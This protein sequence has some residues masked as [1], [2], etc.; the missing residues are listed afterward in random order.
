MTPS[1]LGFIAEATPIRSSAEDAPHCIANNT[2]DSNAGVHLWNLVM[3]HPCKPFTVVPIAFALSIA[4]RSV[5]VCK[6]G[7]VGVLR[8]A[9]KSRIRV[10]IRVLVIEREQ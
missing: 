8:K 7:S 6:T 10:F 5:S 4:A 2:I 1:A 9:R 3:A